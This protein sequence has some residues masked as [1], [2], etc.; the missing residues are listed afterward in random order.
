M[1][2]YKVRIEFP[3]PG[4]SQYKLL[5]TALKNETG[6]SFRLSSTQ[7]SNILHNR[8]EYDVEGN[9]S[10]EDLGSLVSKVS[11]KINKDYSFTI[12]RHKVAVY[13]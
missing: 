9:I 10:I 2:K 12:Q 1:A 13:N 5:S 11:A 4:S 7:P 3:Q 8:V 6:K